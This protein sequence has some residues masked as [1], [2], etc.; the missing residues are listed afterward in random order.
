MQGTPH[1]QSSI[2]SI[3]YSASGQ[4]LRA[5]WRILLQTILLGVFTCI[6]AF[7]VIWFGSRHSP[8]WSMGFITLAECFAITVSIIYARRFIDKRSFVSLGVSLKGS[9]IQDLLAGVGISFLMVALIFAIGMLFGWIDVVR[10]AW[11]EDGIATA[12]GQS[13]I[14]MLIFILV[15]WQE[16]LLSRG[17]QLQNIADGSNLYWAVIISSILFSLFHLPNPGANWSS[18]FGVLLAGLLLSFGYVSTRQLWLPIGI[19]FGWNFFEGVVFGFPVSGMQTYTLARIHTT[20]PELW[21]GGE[22]GPEAGLLII[23]AMILG[24]VLIYLYS[25][26]WV[27]HG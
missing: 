19:H 18:A 3:F 9:W 16:E 26:K 24:A 20:G 25:K 23:L 21:I 1:R 14:W 10:W 27:K 12:A 22:F 11:V 5:G 17:Y 13:L 8:T 7:P 2:V 4:R 6:M 15:A